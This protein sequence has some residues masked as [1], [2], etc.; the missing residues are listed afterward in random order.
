MA[1]VD[2]DKVHER[3]ASA[4][5]KWLKYGDRDVLPFWVA[6]MDFQTPGFIL[7]A[8]QA[9]LEHPVLG[10]T[11]PPEALISAF[12]DWA[13]RRYGWQLHPDWLVAFTSLVPG[14]NAAVRTVGGDGDAMVVMTPIYPP[15]LKTAAFNRREEIR[16]PLVIEQGRWIMD[17]GD[18]EFRVKDV[19]PTTIMLSNPQNPTGRVYTSTELQAFAEL[20]LRYN[21]VIVSDDIH[22]GL[23]LE[24]NVSHVPI[25]TLDKDVANNTI[26]LISH[27]KS[28]NVAGLQ[29]AFAVIPNPTLREQFIAAKDG[30]MSSVSPLAYAAAI[31]AYND[32][33]TWLSELQG[34]LRS[35][36]DLLTATVA[37][38]PNLKMCA[39]IEGT[40]LAWLDAR[41]IPV[42]NHAA[43]FEAFG[44]GLSDGVDF[45]DPGFMRFNFATPRT[46]LEAGL[47]RLQQA[48][49]SA[50]GH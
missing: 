24:E 11:D 4:S 34:Y 29:S 41:A 15:F 48:S 45:G 17:L 8:I 39:P 5:S 14:L 21:T 47:E 38:L 32:R 42:H 28:Y 12:V 40:H 26:T 31:A 46:T 1:I 16:S 36:R 30:W 22:W 50:P 33:S 7:D 2:F 44:L 35:N 18:I 43:Y 20:C 23:C 13:D 19:S 25:A 10:Y 3:R 37:A 49:Q 9:R 27:T 6:D